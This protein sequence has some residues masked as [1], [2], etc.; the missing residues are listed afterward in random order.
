VNGFPFYLQM[1][2]PPKTEAPISAQVF[3]AYIE[4]SHEAHL[5]IYDDDFAMVPVVQLT[6][7]HRQRNGSEGIHLYPSA[8]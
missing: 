2:I 8:F 4:P 7:Q 3:V 6:A 5:A 1:R